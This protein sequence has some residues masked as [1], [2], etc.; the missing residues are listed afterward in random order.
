MF[1]TMH[2]TGSLNIL[3][4]EADDIQRL[5]WTL[6]G[7][8]SETWQEGTVPIRGLLTPYQVREYLTRRLNCWNGT[9][10]P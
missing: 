7:P 2:A 1:F 4:T 3:I 9:C 6:F 5:K 8:Q 10:L